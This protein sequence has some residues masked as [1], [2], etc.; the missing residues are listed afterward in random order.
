M[1][2][3]LL[4]HGQCRDIPFNR[5]PADMWSEVLN[6][7]AGDGCMTPSNSL[8]ELIPNTPPTEYVWHF[9]LTR[10]WNGAVWEDQW[11]KIVTT[12]AGGSINDSS[13]TL[14][15]YSRLND[16]LDINANPPQWLTNGYTAQEANNNAWTGGRFNGWEV[17]NAIGSITGAGNGMFPCGINMNVSPQPAEAVVLPGWGM[18]AEQ[19][20]RTY[21]MRPYRD[22]LIAM[23][24]W[25]GTTGRYETTVF[26]S[27]AAAGGLP[28][29]WTPTAANFAGDVDLND[30]PGPLI[31]GHVLGDDFIIFK[32]GS[33][34]RMS[35][36]GGPNVFAF[37]TLSTTAGV[38]NRNCIVEYQNR[39]IVFGRS[40]IYAI[41]SGGNVESMMTDGVRRYLYAQINAN[42]GPAYDNCSLQ[43]SGA[44]GR[45]Y[46]FYGKGATGEPA[47][48]QDA[49]VLDLRSGRWGHADLGINAPATGGFAAVAT[50]SRC[51]S[52]T[53]TETGGSQTYVWV[54]N[55][56][57]GT[58]VMRC[59]N[60]PIPEWVN[61]GPISLT[62]RAIDLDEPQ[63]SKTVSG[64][65]LLCDADTA[66]GL[67]VRLT[68]RQVLDGT[69]TEDSGDLIWTSGT[70]QQID[71]LVSGKFFDLTVSQT[72][73][74]G[75][76]PWK[77]YGIEIEYNMA[78]NW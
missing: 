40:D 66:T 46:A 68:G 15:R 31:D 62:R 27:D 45:L 9:R 78:G 25:V 7:K 33:C 2:K 30:T 19:E 61:S 55:L 8:N 39:L 54:S 6:V 24:K 5:A 53:L 58:G 56:G 67:T 49:L 59:F 42:T 36:T 50:A 10:G 64:I 20:W 16:M 26:W 70:T 52:T 43:L 51:Q 28:A 17:F 12:G 60:D 34:I 22:F 29:T 41:D 75:Y 77:L 74:Q 44:E 32:S 35:F 38:M 76:G 4:M 37:A 21:A 65:R 71:C 1:L 57:A 48:M 14:R 11:L 73:G 47:Y 3:R 63:Q 13:I 23:Q 72:N 18:T 69:A